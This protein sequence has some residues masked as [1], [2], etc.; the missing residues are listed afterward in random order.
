MHHPVA[1]ISRSRWEADLAWQEKNPEGRRA[2]IWYPRGGRVDL[3][4]H[5]GPGYIE[6]P[7]GEE[8]E[9]PDLDQPTARAVHTDP[10]PA[11]TVKL[12]WVE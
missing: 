6:H 4:R 3:I 8:V 2:A 12:E 10:G 11:V 7:G 1:R 5:S 9:Y